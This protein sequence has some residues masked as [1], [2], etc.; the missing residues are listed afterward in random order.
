[1]PGLEGRGQK[2]GGGGDY[3]LLSGCTVRSFCR[4]GAVVEATGH[5]TLPCPPPTPT[6]QIPAP[7]PS[8]QPRPPPR[9][10]C[11]SSPVSAREH[12]LQGVLNGAGDTVFSKTR[13]ASGV[14]CAQMMRQRVLLFVLRLTVERSGAGCY[15]SGGVCAGTKP[16]IHKLTKNNNGGLQSAEQEH[17]TNRDSPMAAGIEQAARVLLDL[18][19]LCKYH[20]L[21]SC[22]LVEH[23]ATDWIK[24]ACVGTACG[25]LACNATD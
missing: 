21:S 16:V 19:G 10:Q 8:P 4:D 11:C 6:P 23:I 24:H 13:Y 9:A 25:L 2:G 1:M 12:P 5:V 18:D 20:H 22:G 7:P 17:L 3:S 14:H 15:V